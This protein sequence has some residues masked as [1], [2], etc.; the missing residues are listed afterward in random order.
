MGI[1]ES[2][3]HINSN[4]QPLSSIWYHRPWH[5]TNHTLQPFFK[6]AVDAKCSSPRQLRYGE[7]QG[8]CS[9]ANL[10]TCYCS[11][12]KDQ[13]DNYTALAAFADDHSI[14]NNF[15]AG[16][17]VQEHKIK[18]DLEEAFTQLK[19]WVDTMHLKLNP[20]KAEYILPLWLPAAA[21]KDITRTSQCPWWPYCSKWHSEI[22][23]RISGPTPK[24]QEAH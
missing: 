7:P 14:C 17:K 2:E 16:N 18:T 8:S 15:K 9:G 11:L 10:F 6:V 19:D 23:G 12:I 20:D 4:P 13:I 24:F 5:P 1:W 21:K 3:Y 22:S